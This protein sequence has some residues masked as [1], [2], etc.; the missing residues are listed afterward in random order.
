[1][2]WLSLL[3]RYQNWCILWDQGTSDFIR[4]SCLYPSM[5]IWCPSI[6]NSVCT[7][8]FVRLKRNSRQ[9]ISITT[10]F[11]MSR[12]PSFGDTVT[13]YLRHILH[14]VSSASY[15]FVSAHYLE[16]IVC[17]RAMSMY[18]KMDDTVVAISN[19]QVSRSLTHM[20]DKNGDLSSNYQL[21]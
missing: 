8:F 1:M 10:I 14:R 20:N 6:S 3:Y 5:R 2:W 4:E 12:L 9:I 19:R 18:I 13:T 16:L 7:R 15:P 17:K 21:V 11:P